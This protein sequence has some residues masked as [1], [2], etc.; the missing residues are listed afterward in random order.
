MKRLLIIFALT[1]LVI[2]P[3]ALAD[4]PA[5]AAPA[6]APAAPAPAV[7]TAAAPAD[8]TAAPEDVI[9]KDPTTFFTNLVEA[10]QSKRWSPVIGSVL[11]VLVW[12][13]RKFLWKKLPKKVVP[14]VALGVGA[15]ATVGLGMVGGV[16]WWKA[17]ISGLVSGSQA[18]ALWELGSSV[19]PKKAEEPAR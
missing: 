6:A 19:A 4:N 13:I 16:T 11:L 10:V 1:C 7:N 5:P 17:L 8:T 2:A 14:W 12:A 9:T 18:I 3:V 15:V